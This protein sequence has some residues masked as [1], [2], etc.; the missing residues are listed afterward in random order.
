M[1]RQNPFCSLFYGYTSQKTLSFAKQN[2]CQMTAL[3]KLVSNWVQASTKQKLSSHN[4]LD[5]R[6]FLFAK[7]S[8]DWKSTTNLVL[9]KWFCTNEVK[10]IVF[11]ILPLQVAKK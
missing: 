2:S 3:L 8:I 7:W 9:P 10:L 5:D 6:Q 11:S 1:A 4:L